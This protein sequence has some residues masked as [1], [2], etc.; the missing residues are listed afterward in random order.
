MA[1]AEAPAGSGLGATSLA[2]GVYD[3]TIE[4]HA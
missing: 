2:A 4:L 3:V 1:S